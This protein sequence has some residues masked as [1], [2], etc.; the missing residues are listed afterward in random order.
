MNLGA[1]HSHLPGYWAHD[2]PRQLGR[3]PAQHRYFGDAGVIGHRRRDCLSL[4]H[5]DSEWGISGGALPAPALVEEITSD[6]CE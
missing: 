5:G 6:G 2:V 3:K 4:S 1:E